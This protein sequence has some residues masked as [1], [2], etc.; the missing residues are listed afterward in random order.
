MFA[1]PI[2]APQAKAASQ[3]TPTFAPKTPQRTHLW[4]GAL[5]NHAGFRLPRFG[6][7][8]AERLAESTSIQ[9]PA[10]E[11]I[12]SPHGIQ[13]ASWDF[14]KIPLFAPALSGG[15]ESPPALLQRKVA[16]GTV[17]DPLEHEADR[18][19]DH[20]MRMP[21]PRLG[22]DPTPR[23]GVVGTKASST[24][25]KR[26]HQM[27]RSDGEVP[28]AVQ[29]LPR[30]ARRQL[31]I[32]TDAEVQRVVQTDTKGVTPVQTLQRTPKGKTDKPPAEQTP[33]DWMIILRPRPNEIEVEFSDFASEQDVL[34]IIS[35][36]GTL[37]ST[38]TLRKSLESITAWVLRGPPDVDLSA[39][40]PLFGAAFA[41]RL[42]AKRAQK[43][44]VEQG[45]SAPRSEAPIREA[46]ARF[47]ARHSGHDVKVL[48]RID[49]ALAR[50]TKN[51]PN[52]LLAYYEHYAD[53]EL[54]TTVDNPEDSGQT[55]WG[56]TGIRSDVLELKARVITSDPLSFLGGTLIHEFVHKPHGG[57]ENAA[58]Q[59]PKE[60][61][62]YGVEVVLAE[63]M[64]DSKRMGFIYDRYRNSSFDQ[65]LGTDKI[66]YATQ[67]IISAL[68]QVI[69]S[70][71][72]ESEAQATGR[73][74]AEEA[75]RMSVE[76]MSK[77]E[78]D[79]GKTLKDFIAKHSP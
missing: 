39:G 55:N 14:S 17:N 74:S 47:R 29:N 77:N 4:S 26:T 61:K 24:Q 68:Y 33:P 76:F 44:S 23:Q 41:Y 51:N 78:A 46:R 58:A 27:S 72:T 1:P 30:S 48:D 73:I 75:R 28:V 5:S 31:R 22:I 45:I 42:E 64:G 71:V 19:A 54:N 35:K 2:K 12:A 43:S 52:L 9:E 15:S 53:H 66:F 70:G 3:T 13:G 21:D 6:A 37:P 36:D 79:Y 11:R 32:H 63:R 49:A 16:I 20:V 38:L 7:Q 50:A 57:K 62:S 60:A 67:K 56:D 34:R 10:P 59:A 65:G 69:D 40:L 25:A 8:E 18:V